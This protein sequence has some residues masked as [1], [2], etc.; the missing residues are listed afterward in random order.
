LDV[1]LTA[2]EYKVTVD[3]LPCPVELL[4]PTM[5]TC[6]IDVS[7]YIGVYHAVVKVLQLL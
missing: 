3:N 1:A 4:T 6:R 2:D 5:L 7:A